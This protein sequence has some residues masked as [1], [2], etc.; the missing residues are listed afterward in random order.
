METGCD[1]GIVNG[2]PLNK[3]FFAKIAD[4]ISEACKDRESLLWPAI[5]SNIKCN[6]RCHFLPNRSVAK[7]VRYYSLI[8]PVY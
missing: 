3:V 7:S 6:S 8:K 2:E 4:S 5:S 1:T